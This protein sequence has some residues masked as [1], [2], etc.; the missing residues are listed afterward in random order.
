VRIIVVHSRYRSGALSGENR[1]VD[2][3]IAL[4]RAAGHEVEALQRET[5]G[6][7]A[8][9]LAVRTIWSRDAVREGLERIRAFQP[10]V[11]H[12]HNMFPAVSPAIVSAAHAAGVPTVMTLHNFRL[13]CLPATFLRRGKICEDC[14]GKLPWRGIAHRCYRGSL[15]ASAALGV[16][17]SLHRD[18]LRTFD[19]TT[20]FAAVSAFIRQK[21]IEAGFPSE[22][23]VVKPNFVGEQLR[24]E[25]PGNYFLYV[26][27]LSPEKGIVDLVKAWSGF[28]HALKVVGDGPD[29][30]RLASA[31]PANVELI[32][33][34]AAERVSDLIRGSR[35]VVLPSVWY[36]GQPRVVLE[37]FASGVPVIAS[38]LGGLSELVTHNRDGLL[39]RPGD[40]VGWFE[41]AAVLAD[42]RRSEAM[43]EAAWETWRERYTAAHALAALESTY[44]RVSAGS[45]RPKVTA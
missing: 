37:A 23:I 31:A 24:R 19:R 4:L 15:P 16:S 9:S 8:V 14:L 17:I 18:V 2:D 35:A 21:H 28:G 43:G 29:R 3:E 44:A 45:E 27:R 10:D 20:F 13:S 7:R 36:E 11:L 26:G 41:A 32:G 1:V 25:G 34:V 33:G 38:D 39:V 30:E 42:D 22:K 5:H 6:E 12:L 40:S